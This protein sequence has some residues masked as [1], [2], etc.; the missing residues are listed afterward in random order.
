MCAHSLICIANKCQ[1]HAHRNRKQA[2]FI[3]FTYALLMCASYFVFDLYCFTFEFTCSLSYQST[4]VN[5]PTK[6]IIADISW[7]HGKHG[8]LNRIKISCFS[9]MLSM[10]AVFFRLFGGSS[11]RN[12]DN[13]TIYVTHSVWGGG[14]W[15]HVVNVCSSI[16]HCHRCFYTCFS[17]YSMV[18]AQKKDSHVYFSLGHLFSNI[19]GMCLSI[20]LSRPAH[21]FVSVYLCDVIVWVKAWPISS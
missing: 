14:F 2:A 7:I 17:V 5:G 15:E 1:T 19:S 6:V 12:S 9:N 8:I 21:I 10:I 11:Q 3:H 16:Y 13:S 4:T 20:S 18:F